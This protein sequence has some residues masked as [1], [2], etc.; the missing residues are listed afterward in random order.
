MKNTQRRVRRV[1]PQTGK[2]EKSSGYSY[3]ANR[4]MRPGDT[5]RGEGKLDRSKVPR[6]D[7][8][9]VNHIITLLLLVVIITILADLFWLNSKPKVYIEGS[10]TTLLS[11]TETYQA[12]AEKLISGSFLNRNKL[13]INVTSIANSMQKEFPELAAVS[14][15]FSFS[16]HQAQLDITP[17][18]PILLLNN[19]NATYAVGSDGTVIGAATLTT[20]PSLDNLGLPLVND[21]VASVKKGSQI[22]STSDVSFIQYVADEF[23]AQHVALETMSLPVATRELDVTPAGQSYYIKFNLQTAPKEQVGSYLAVE[24]YLTQNKITPSQYVDVRIAGRAYYK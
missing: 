19:G 5:A 22:L 11:S 17:A 20:L 3:Y 4:D 16:G 6:S 1:Q 8:L 24:Q 12:A 15:T 10:S 13:T 23:K 14:V 21:T 2:S 18:Q 7:S 9:W